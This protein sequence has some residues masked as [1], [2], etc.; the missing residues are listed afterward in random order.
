M[1]CGMLTVLP[2]R[3]LTMCPDRVLTMQ[4]D[5]AQKLIPRNF[6]IL[7]LLF[8][9]Y[10]LNL[11]QIFTSISVI[12]EILSTTQRRDQGL[13]RRD[14]RMNFGRKCTQAWYVGAPTVWSGDPHLHCASYASCPN[15]ELLLNPSKKLN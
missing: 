4:S 14:Q 12:E 7:L 3:A 2:N 10:F 5:R 13:L 9:S 8:P 1:P 11:A 15:A 6:K